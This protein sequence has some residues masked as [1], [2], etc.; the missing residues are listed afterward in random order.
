MTDDH[1]PVPIIR[2]G[3]DQE[4]EPA[5]D[6][7]GFEPTVERSAIEPRTFTERINL[8]KLTFASRLVGWCLFLIVILSLVGNYLPGNNSED[9]LLTTAIEVLKLVLTTALGF[10][11]AK[12]DSAH[13]NRE[14]K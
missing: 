8:D 2:G 7:D 1:K 5:A 4:Y 11:F 9:H 6:V 14:S 13:Q 10:V 3:V 12:W